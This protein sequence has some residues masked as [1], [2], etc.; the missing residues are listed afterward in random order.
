MVIAQ[1]TLTAI[2]PDCLT[3][4]ISDEQGSQSALVAVRELHNDRCGGDPATAPKL[5][6]LRIA[7]ATGRVW[8]DARSLN[9]ELEEL[10]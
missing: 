3:F 9:G 6:T 8:S 2:K 1:H 10:R 4:E 7:P 5:F